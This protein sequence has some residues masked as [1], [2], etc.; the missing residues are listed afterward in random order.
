MKSRLAPICIVAAFCLTACSDDTSLIDAPPAGDSSTTTTAAPET[1]TSTPTTGDAGPTT[2]TGPGLTTTGPDETSTGKEDDSS[3]GPP[4]DPTTGA[5][6]ECPDRPSGFYKDCVNGAV[7]DGAVDDATCLVDVPDAESFGIC[8]LLCQDDC[9]CFAD[10]GSSGAVSAC[11]P[12]L[13]GGEKACV[14]DCSGGKTCPSGSYCYSDL[15]ICVYGVKVDKE[16]DLDLDAVSLDDHTLAPGEMTALNFEVDNL[17]TVTVDA[18]FIVRAVLSKNDI[19]GDDDDIIVIEGSFPEP[20]E[21]STPTGWYIDIEIPADVFDGVYHVAMGL[22]TED[23]VAESDETNNVAFD[24]VLLIISGNPMPGNADL[25]LENALAAAHQVLQGAQTSFGF[26]VKNLAAADVPA[27]SVGLYYSKD[28]QVTTADTLICTHTDADGLAGMAQ[29]A[30]QVSCAVPK[31]VGAHYF[32][33]IVDPADMLDELDE[34]NNADVDA[35]PVTITAP[36]VDLVMGAVTSDDN[37]V[38]TGQLVTL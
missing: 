6:E 22:D 12:L 15:D 14:L 9:D 28:P 27:Y 37:T 33:A 20:V 23:D 29:E 11:V 17:G 2:T 10:P 38:D 7:C 5:P 3:S 32:G 30:K 34:A 36:V 25:G 31:L 26:T 18:G 8:S 19:F 35:D 1:G 4:P 24:P 16:A 21:P 13:E